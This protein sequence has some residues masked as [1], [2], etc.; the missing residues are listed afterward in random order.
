VARIH[1]ALAAAGRGPAA[2]P[3]AASVRDADRRVS[4]KLPSSLEAFTGALQSG[5]TVRWTIRRGARLDEDA[6]RAGLGRRDR[7]GREAPVAR[8]VAHVYSGAADAGR[9]GRVQQAWRSACRSRP[10]ADGGERIA[11]KVWKAI[12]EIWTSAQLAS[13]RRCAAWS[14]ASN[15]SPTC[16]RSCAH[17]LPALDE[18]VH[19]S[20]QS[21]AGLSLTAEVSRAATSLRIAQNRAVEVFSELYNIPTR[22][23]VDEAY[24]LIHELRKEL[25]ALKKAAPES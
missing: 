17:G 3:A 15:R 4:R 1:G 25:R 13:A 2:G 23:E 5:G 6:R 14:S 19:E 18:A 21:D 20:M 7:S 9:L 11:G 10:G 16:R 8:R 24:R 22:A 12:G